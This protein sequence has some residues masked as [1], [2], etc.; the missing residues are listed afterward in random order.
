[1][2][3]PH[4]RSRL[5]SADDIMSPLGRRSERVRGIAP[6][7]PSLQGKRLGLL[8]NSKQNANILLD[9]I[10]NILSREYGVSSVTYRQK[11]TAARPGGDFGVIDALS[12][13][14][15]VVVNAYGDCG[16]CTSWC[17]HDSVQL[18]LR[19]IPVATVNT[20]EFVKLGQFEAISLGMPGLPIVTVPHP[21]GDQP[22]A[23]VREKARAVVA[24][25]V[26]VLT[27][28]AGE[29]EA[30]YTNHYIVTGDSLRGENL[31]CPL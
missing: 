3:A 28:D 4:E 2:D 12:E 13:T 18:E 8:D 22:E 30:E 9:E 17:V 29:L 26:K 11:P 15:D 31:F 25:I 6:R 24:E 19:G 21:I 7:F 27:T 23:A 16:S 1:M 10:G 14:C 20:R 5:G